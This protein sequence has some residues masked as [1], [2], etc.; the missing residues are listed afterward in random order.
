MGVRDCE[1]ELGNDMHHFFVA[2]EQ[3]GE[4]KITIT[5][6]DVNHIRNVLRMEAGE[7]ITVSGGEGK[8]Y[9][10]EVLVLEPDRVEAGIMWVQETEA[11]LPSKIY[12]FQGLPKG[13]KMELIIQKAVELGVYEIIPVATK[14]TVVKLDK[15]KSESKRKRW[16]SISE[17]AAK[18][19]KRLIVPEITSVM[20]F[21][22]AV[23]YAAGMDVKLMPY[24]LAE[25]ME[26]TRHLLEGI[27]PGQSVAIFIGPEGGF[28]A[29]EA[30][31]AAAE[32]LQPI[33]LGKRILRTETAGMT[34]LSVLMYLLEGRTERENGSIS[35]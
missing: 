22:E 17:S 27:V 25:G 33:T 31:L 20:S 2:P 6:S 29:E 5:G 30:K 9:R 8:E 11:E 7:Q 3:I 12:L 1:K 32:G 14:R 18:Q 4:K 28:S 35:G 15:K 13:D 23:E 26:E 34:V 10:C 16:Q 24:E 19:S 21:R